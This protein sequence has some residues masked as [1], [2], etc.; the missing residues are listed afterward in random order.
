MPKTKIGVKD[1]LEHA[2]ECLLSYIHSLH[3][4]ETYTF[5]HTLEDNVNT[6]PIYIYLQSLEDFHLKNVWNAV[7]TH[8]KSFQT[9]YEG[10]KDTLYRRSLYSKQSYLRRH[11]ECLPGD[12]DALLTEFIQG[13]PLKG[14]FVIRTLI[15]HGCPFLR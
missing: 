4:T 11:H 7:V 3:T 5:L 10:S 6:E 2:P 1:L 12:L 15:Q 14:I 8:W 13:D 9:Q